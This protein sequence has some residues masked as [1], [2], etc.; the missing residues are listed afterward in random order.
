M[1]EELMEYP[2]D[3]TFPKSS[4]VNVTKVSF[5]NRY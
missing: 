3:K 2:W 5:H 1:S 4:L